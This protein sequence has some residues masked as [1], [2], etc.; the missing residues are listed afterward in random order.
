MAVYEA[1]QTT[2]YDMPLRLIIIC[3]Y[4]I[5]SQIVF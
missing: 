3:V 2:F 4:P 5:K 1:F